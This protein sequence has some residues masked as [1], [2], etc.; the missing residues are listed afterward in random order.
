MKKIFA[1]ALVLGALVIGTL[2]SGFEI[3][4]KEVGAAACDLATGAGCG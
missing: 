3:Q 4:I 1:A 2:T